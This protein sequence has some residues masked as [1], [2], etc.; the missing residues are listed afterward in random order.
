MSS[1][2]P[3]LHRLSPPLLPSHPPCLLPLTSPTPPLCLTLNP[4]F[5]PS[6]LATCDWRWLPHITTMTSCRSR[7][8]GSGRTMV[9]RQLTYLPT[10]LNESKHSNIC[11]SLMYC[12]SISLFTF[13]TSQADRD[14]LV[15]M[16]CGGVHIPALLTSQAQREQQLC[17]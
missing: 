10:A 15:H 13:S 3:C 7:C 14:T 16:F 1:L 2:H 4:S 6:P 17:R 12:V 9:S 5:L 8:S 11:S